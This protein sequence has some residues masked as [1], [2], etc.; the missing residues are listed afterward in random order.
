MT[1]ITNLPGSTVTQS[2]NPSNLRAPASLESTEPR[3]LE[4]DSVTISAEAIEAQQTQQ[5]QQTEPATT[6]GSGAPPAND[7]PNAGGN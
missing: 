5:A 3:N 7:P 1:S 6:G 4:E 2:Y